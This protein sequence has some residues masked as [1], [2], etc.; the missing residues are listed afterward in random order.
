M[1]FLLIQVFLVA[2]L[3]L[4][5][6]ELPLN[7]PLISSCPNKVYNEELHA[8]N[9]F[10]IDVDEE[11]VRDIRAEYETDVRPYLS[12]GKSTENFC[13]V[14]PANP[15]T[16]TWEDVDG[17]ATSDIKWYSVNNEETYKKY[18][19]HVDRLGL[20][21][22]V[23]RKFIDNDADDITVYTMFLIVRSHCKKHTFHVDWS[24][25]IKTQVLNV[26]IP[27]NDF[28]LHLAYEDIDGETRQYEYKLG[29]AIGFGGGFVHSTEIGES[30]PEDVLL[31]VYL[32]SNDPK[33]WK[34][35]RRNI[36]DE[37]EHY[38]SPLKG[39]IHNENYQDEE[40]CQ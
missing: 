25:R 20:K 4:C 30:D 23:A 6:A 16:T 32:G 12:T 22:I 33:I 29:K 18:L 34:Y 15:N 11:I 27:L 21:D 37:L 31:S 40:L 24:N 8:N 28:Q 7:E 19:H 1:W 13:L 5:I 9:V 35:A 39:F 36:D 17:T 38:M 3:Q 2:L 26:L 14:T 10:E